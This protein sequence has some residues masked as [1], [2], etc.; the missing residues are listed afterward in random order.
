MLE[1]GSGRHCAL[2][3]EGLNVLPPSLSNPHQS[4]EKRTVSP[5]GE[6]WTW[7]GIDT[8]GRGGKKVSRKSWF[9]R[10]RF[11]RGVGS[12]WAEVGQEG[13]LAAWEGN[14]AWVNKKVEKKSVQS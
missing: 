3:W 12:T 4:G 7:A 2:Q 10:V 13:T 6:G 8:H 11:P 1:K 9:Q 5:G 14:L